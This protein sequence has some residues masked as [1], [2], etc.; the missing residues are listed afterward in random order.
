MGGRRSKLHLLQCHSPAG[1]PGVGQVGSYSLSGVTGYGGAI[2]TAKGSEMRHGLPVIE[3]FMHYVAKQENGCW[4]WTGYI[5]K[6]GY[7]QFEWEK[8]GI[9]R[10]W[11]TNRASY[12]LF[13]GHIPLGKYVCHSCDV[14]SCVN[15]DHLWLGTNRDNYWDARNK[16]LL[17]H[18]HGVNRKSKLTDDDVERIRSKEGL[19]QRQLAKKY[20][21]S[22]RYIQMLQHH[23]YR[24]LKS[25]NLI[26]KPVALP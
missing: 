18:Y 2:A 11:R 26:L 25:G 20:N 13:K 10:S 14:K 9:K 1:C 5:N 21:V 7:G 8:D 23:K 15:P 4:L 16:G 22:R 17:S 3:R 12:V 24:N 19:T 6:Y